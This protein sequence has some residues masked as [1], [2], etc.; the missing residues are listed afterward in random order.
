MLS[1]RLAVIALSPEVRPRLMQR[2]RDYVRRG[3]LVLE[4]WMAGHDDTF[5][6]SGPQA[7]AIGFVRYCLDIN[8]TPLADQLRQEKSVL[9]VPGDHFGMDR[10]LRLSSGLPRD[11]LVAALDRVH[12][13][14]VERR[15]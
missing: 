5:S 10:F 6:I 13:F 8:S 12:E 4:Q 3:H 7:G 1:N 2:T 14:I 11:Y 15:D 9:V